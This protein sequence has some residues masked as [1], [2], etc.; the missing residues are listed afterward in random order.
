[1]L[2]FGERYS[3]DRCSKHHDAPYWSKDSCENNVSYVQCVDRVRPETAA[4]RKAKAEVLAAFR[5]IGALCIATIAPRNT[6]S[7]AGCLTG[8][9]K[10]LV[11]QL[12]LS[13]SVAV[14]VRAGQ[15]TV[16]I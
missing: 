7:S 15:Q 4:E 11:S 8:E 10:Q 2:D 3:V 5:T 12:S 16:D 9:I 14:Q 6:L 1:M 13:S